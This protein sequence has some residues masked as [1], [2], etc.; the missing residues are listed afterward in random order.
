M[1]R[2]PTS[3]LTIRVFD[4]PELE[5]STEL[6][7]TLPAPQASA[8]LP[9]MSADRAAQI[10]RSSERQTRSRLLADWIRYHVSAVTGSRAYSTVH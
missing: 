8:L 3:F 2:R 10:L 9:A 5:A 6:I 7:R 1:A 4:E